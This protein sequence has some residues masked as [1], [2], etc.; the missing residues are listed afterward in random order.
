MQAGGRGLVTS[1]RLIIIRKSIL[2]VF[3]QS[4]SE[5]HCLDT[6][7]P[8]VTVPFVTS[9]RSECQLFI[10]QPTSHWTMTCALTGI[11]R[12]CAVRAMS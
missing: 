12:K 8:E 3:L 6:C 2:L 5:I 9:Q 11:P 10:F 4:C 7:L 1:H